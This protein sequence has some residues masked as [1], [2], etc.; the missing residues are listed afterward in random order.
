MEIN[1]QAF[2]KRMCIIHANNAFFD[3]EKKILPKIERIPYKYMR[4]SFHRPT[5]KKYL[6]YR[7]RRKMTK[8]KYN[9]FSKPLIVNRLP[10]IF[11]YR[12]KYTSTV[13]KTLEFGMGKISSESWVFDILN[14]M[15]DELDRN[16]GKTI[17]L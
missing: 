7:P 17:L 1:D 11:K 2:S 8:F 13:T 10:P 5:Y 3:E 12:V 16:R 4:K 6:P 9:Y 15:N 14:L